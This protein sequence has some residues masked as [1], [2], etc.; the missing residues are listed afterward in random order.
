MNS[1]CGA[2][3]IVPDAQKVALNSRCGGRGRLP[4]SPAV[5]TG[6]SWHLSFGGCQNKAQQT[7]RLKTTEIDSLTALEARNQGVSAAVFPLRLWVECFLASSWLLLVDQ[8]P[9]FLGLQ[10]HRSSL[11]PQ[12]VLPSCLHIVVFL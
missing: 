6:V 1:V 2:L 9:E 3:S 5:L 11:C 8:S 10:P 4:S 12:D 7:G